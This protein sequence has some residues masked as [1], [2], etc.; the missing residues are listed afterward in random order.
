M[1]N[2]D[3]VIPWVD[4]KDPIWQSEL[5]KI[6]PERKNKFD[7]ERYRDWDLLKFW[8][9]GVEKNASWVRKIHF[10]T[11]GHIPSWL[12][13]SNDKINIV[14]HEDFIPKRHLPLFSASPI[15]IHIN[16]IHGLS[17]KFVYFNDDMFITDSI[18]ESDFFRHNL[19]CDTG[20]FNA[21]TPGGISHMMLNDL[22]VIK[23]YFSK[24]VVIKKN[25]F[26]WFNVKYGNK[27]LRNIA[28]LPWPGFTGF[29]EH[30]LPQAYL[31]TIFDEVWG[32]EKDI[33]TQ[34]AELKF[35]CDAQLNIYLFRY[36]QLCTGTFY[37]INYNNNGCY[38]SLSDES[39]E[40]ICFSI[41]NKKHKII[42]IND[43]EGLNFEYCQQKLISAFE[44]ILPTKSSFE[45]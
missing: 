31:K 20:V 27:V 3:F 29:Y 9:R 15:E 44:E 35:R 39:V 18:A 17:N 36:W 8:F 14:K 21:I 10:V 16:K 38:F 11:F 7:A 33:L 40:N 5:F 42:T 23:K 1:S 25:P 28:L 43:N 32:K 26:K 19:P 34:T 12:D 2:V 37:P 22:E 45:R 13:T 30:H 41:R 6:C 4:G 24:R